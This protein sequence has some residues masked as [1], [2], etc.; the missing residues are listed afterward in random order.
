M[1]RPKSFVPNSGKNV[2]D[3]SGSMEH[4]NSERSLNVIQSIMGSLLIPEPR[5]ES[6]ADDVRIRYVAEPP[7]SERNSDSIA[8]D[9]PSTLSAGMTR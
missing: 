7:E 9:S 8:G 1:K 4:P 3:E 2:A 6:R 5:E